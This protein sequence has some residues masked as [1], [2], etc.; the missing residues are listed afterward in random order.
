MWHGRSR[1][2]DH[3][4]NAGESFRLLGRP[5]GDGS[6]FQAAVYLATAPKSNAVYMAQKQVTDL[7]EK[8]GTSRCPCISVIR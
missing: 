3:A 4:L 7:V 1:G 5:E 2:I 8:P 6:L